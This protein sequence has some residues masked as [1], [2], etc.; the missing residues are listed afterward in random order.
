MSLIHIQI[1][2][3]LFLGLIICSVV[4]RLAYRRT[5]SFIPGPPSQS[6][7]FGHIREL[8]Q[9]EAAQIDFEW[10]GRY[11]SIVRFKG[12]FS[13]DRLL[14][15]DPKAM[16][17]IYQTSAYRFEKLKVRQEVARSV[18]GYGLLWADGDNHKRQ[19]KVMLPG[20]G[21]PETKA[22]LPIFA[23]YAVQEISQS[24]LDSIVVDI[25]KWTS[26]ATLDSFGMAAFEYEFGSM[27]D[28]EN[29]LNK[30]YTNLFTRTFALPSSISLFVQDMW[31]YI[32]RPI[33]EF[34]NNHNP[35]FRACY[36][37]NVARQV[38]GIARS[39]VESKYE[40]LLL[41]NGRRDVMSLLVQANAAQDDQS[42]LSERE[43]LDQMRT[44][45]M[46]GHETIANTISWALYELS[47][48][49][50]IQTCLRKEIH[51]AEARLHSH[52]QSH[53]T[54]ADFEKM[55]LT[56]AVIKEVLRFHPVVYHAHRKASQDEVLP[57]S[58]PIITTSGDVLY[59]L[60]VPKGTK[61]VTSFAAYNR[62]KAIFGE[63]AHKTFRACLGWRFAVLELTCMLVE[64]VSNFDF[65]PTPRSKRLRREACVLM[66]PTVEGE[67]DKGT[68]L[69]LRIRQVKNDLL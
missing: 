54:S 43:M 48:H 62:D 4:F 52:H 55:P 31:Q 44:L 60:P 16:Q 57:L 50:H 24:G 19:R 17:Y 51:A 37:R 18:A 14:V 27:V 22:F 38:N 15:A 9:N 28:S 12:P 39:L 30:V 42:R 40:D 2:A 69:P 6:I 26:R 29:L 45:I 35:A 47:I 8:F 13:E 32:P 21:T 53:F 46:A 66:I 20:F 64:L 23:Y 49:P 33:L 61:I 11:G 58:R 59:E 25:P 1:C 65:S 10:V 63:D 34:Y 3:L 56:Q 7:I 36:A 41:G 5:L 68:Q 67:L